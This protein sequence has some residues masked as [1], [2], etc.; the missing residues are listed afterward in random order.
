MIALT[1][2]LPPLTDAEADTLAAYLASPDSLTDLAAQL[3]LHPSDL[4]VILSSP[5]VQAH[6]EAARTLAELKFTIRALAAREIA[7]QTL[8][9]IAADSEAD[10]TERR[11]A[12]TAII[13]ALAP[14]RRAPAPSHQP[15]PTPSPPPPDLRGRVLDPLPPASPHETAEQPGADARRTDT[16][17]GLLS[18]GERVGHA[19]SPSSP[20]RGGELGD[21]AESPSPEGAVLPR[22]DQE[23]SGATGSSSCPP[24]VHQGF[25][26]PHHPL[27]PPRPPLP[28]A[29]NW[30]P[31]DPRPPDRSTL[32]GSDPEACRSRGFLP[33]S[34]VVRDT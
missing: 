18:L 33:G 7:L 16:D 19:P 30:L 11:R 9:T 6:L 34:G 4:I 1:D 13:R 27:P 23:K 29:V 21:V 5:S 24:P 12:A 17:P 10:I 28:T 22:P 31:Q 20:A 2:Q 26:P 3:N 25:I 15:A 32:R 8:E 14:R